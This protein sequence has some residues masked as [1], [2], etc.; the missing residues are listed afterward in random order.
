MYNVLFEDNVLSR[1][2]K[3]NPK[4]VGV[5]GDPK[6]RCFLLGKGDLSKECLPEGYASVARG[7][8]LMHMRCK[9]VQ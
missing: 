3:A 2:S 8:V 9:G 4:R 7:G 5:E 1:I 6:G